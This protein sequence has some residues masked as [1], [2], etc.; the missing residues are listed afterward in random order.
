MSTIDSMKT[1]VL[2]LLGLLVAWFFA[3]TLPR[4]IAASGFE[5]FHL[6]IGSLRTIGWFPIVLGACAFL[7]C[8]WLFF[9]IGKGTPWPFDPPKE[10]VVSGPYRYVRNPMESSYLLVLFGEVLL[11]ESSALILYLIFNFLFLFMR[12][13]VV[14]EPVLRSRFGQSYEQY[15][16]SVPR[17]VPRLIS[18]TRED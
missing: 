16:K 9:S 12:Q 6:E 17:Y 3:V 4:W 14:E 2:Y 11:F 18:K 7:W 15:E 1:I 10:L 8:Y 13:V 5:P